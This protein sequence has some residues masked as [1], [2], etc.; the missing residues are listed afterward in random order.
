MNFINAENTHIL[1][2]NVFVER[3]LTYR[4][5]FVE[6]FKTMNLIERGEALTYETYSRLADNYVINIKRFIKLGNSYIS[7][8]H[9]EETEFY[10]S[11]NNYFVALI[12]ALNYLDYENN[13][14]NKPQVAKARA[15]IRD[16]EIDFMNEV[17][18]YMG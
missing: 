14:V 15:V 1:E 12:D 10:D 5:V 17:Q 11:L 3:F 6:Y 18:S 4:D 16:S 7:K 9:L 8:Y 2:T 13:M